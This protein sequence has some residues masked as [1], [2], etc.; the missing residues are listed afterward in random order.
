MQIKGLQKLSLIDY[1]PYSAAVIFISGC[2]FR[3][4]FCQNPGIVL[5]SNGIPSIPENEVLAFLEKRKMWLDAVVISGGEPTLHSVLPLFINK[6]RALGYRI[7]LDTN[8]SNPEMLQTL[9]REKLIDCVA[10]DIKSSPEKYTTIA[11]ET[12]HTSLINESI[13]IIIESDIEHIFRTTAFPGLGVADFASIGQWIKGA[14][15]FHIQQFRPEVCLDKSFEALKPYTYNVLLD[16][17]S[18]IEPY[19][20]K[21]EIIY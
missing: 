19:V 11:G 14:K 21:V 15:T 17:K 12:A 7:K 18:A 3:C 8:G 1:P 20:K 2:N 4:K 9:I 6:I 10:M 5:H 16:F 13:K